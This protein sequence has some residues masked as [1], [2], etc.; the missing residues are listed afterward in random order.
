MV[1]DGENGIGDPRRF[2]IF[3]I[4]NLLFSKL[5]KKNDTLFFSAFSNFEI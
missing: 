5:K 3:R 4:L 1:I 2:G